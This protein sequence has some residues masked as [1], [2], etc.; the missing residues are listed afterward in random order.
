M[1]ITKIRRI[2][3]SNVLSLPRELEEIGFLP[4]T[5]VLIEE[6]P[7]GGLWIALAEQVRERIKDEGHRLV[8]EH[9]EALRLLADDDQTAK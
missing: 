2:G 4:G 8:D 9:P 3:N 7:D 1:K 5:S 6:L